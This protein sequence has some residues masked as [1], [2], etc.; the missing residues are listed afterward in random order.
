MTTYTAVTDTETGHL[1]PL[2][3]SLLRRLR[4]NPIAVAEGATGA[5]RIMPAA[6]DLYL[7]SFDISGATYVGLSGLDGLDGILVAMQIVTGGATTN[8]RFRLSDDG[9]AT[10]GSNIAIGS[11]AASATSGMAIFYI[12]LKT[13]RALVLMSP[14][15][16]T[17]AGRTTSYTIPGSGANA[18]QFSFTTGTPTAQAEAW[19]IGSFS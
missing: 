4:D 12:S 7:G 14:I 6:L 11:I 19:G 8:T 16:S 15:G 17:A 18:I 2:T 3:T 10:W 5:P 13:P 1:K 9:G